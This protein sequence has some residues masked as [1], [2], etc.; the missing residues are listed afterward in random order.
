MVEDASGRGVT[1]T[2]L[3]L[4]VGFDTLARDFSGPGD[5]RRFCFYAARRGLAFERA[6]PGRPYDLVVT[7]G[8]GDLSVWSR[9]PR[10]T[11]LILDLV[12]SYLDAPRTDPRAIVRGAAK[13]VFR[14][15]R[16]LHLD[17]RALIEATCRRA[18]AVICAT[19]E[20]QQTL[21]RYCPNVHVILD[22]QPEVECRVKAG[23]EASGVFRM[24]W[25]G[26]PENVVTFRA[27]AHVLRELQRRRPFE[28]HLVTDRMRAIGSTHIWMV[29]TA[30]LVRDV[31]RMD[32]VHLHEWSQDALPAVAM[33]CDLAVIPIPLGNRLLAGK[34]E[35]KL[36]LFWRM[37]LPVVTSA[38]PAYRRTMAAA[39]LDMTCR[40]DE[41]WTR[42]LE[43]YMD[44]EAAR[45]VAGQR[46]Q[47]Y[48]S[49]T[50]T[51]ENLLRCWEDALSSVR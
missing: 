17:Y 4:R 35:N 33:T 48:A 1:R 26:L 37:G 3:P 41:E 20:Q 15:T 34:P 25:E 29:P 13:F 49:R 43:H 11:K 28:L 40:T 2:D 42:M 18:D 16:Y 10:S 36:I 8:G 31:F 21:L 39:S 7:T 50:Y 9:L 6:R 32:G 14:H 30:R 5:R 47:E 46:G 27:I 51:V 44:D 23:Y 22:F 24:V 12:D 45:R 19:E 38:T